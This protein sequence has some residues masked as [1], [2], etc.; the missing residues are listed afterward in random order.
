MLISCYEE[1]K[2]NIYTVKCKPNRPLSF[3][4][5]CVQKES[6]YLHLSLIKADKYSDGG[7]ETSFTTGSNKQ[8]RRMN[9]R[10]LFSCTDAS[11]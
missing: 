9:K 6:D 1:V 8:C 3:V 11:L 10:K 4:S 2:K 7:E 5:I